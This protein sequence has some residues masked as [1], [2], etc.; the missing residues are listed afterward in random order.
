MRTGYLIDN[1]SDFKGLDLFNSE[2][3]TKLEAL[4]PLLKEF[5]I[6]I[7]NSSQSQYKTVA[8]FSEEDT[9]AYYLNKDGYNASSTYAEIIIN[10]S[11]CKKLCLTNFEMFAAIAHEIGHI[12]LFFRED[13][14]S[15]KGQ[16][17][18]V[19]CDM[20]ACKIG[21]A[22]PLSSLLRKLIESHLYS[23]E[24]VDILKNR[25]IYISPYIN[26]DYNR[27]ETKEN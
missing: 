10:I 4:C 23:L 15:Y 24:Q 5:Y 27:V 9:F 12:I 8:K 1:K 14:N 13:K 19:C 6:H 7:R 17:E 21:L 26:N 18:E 20:Y 25:L 16:A 22:V 11:L 3:S 2:Y